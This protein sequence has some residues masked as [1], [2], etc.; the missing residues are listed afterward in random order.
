[1]SKADYYISSGG[2]A[3]VWPIPDFSAKRCLDIGIAAPLLVLTSPLLL[4]LGLMLAA[5]GGGVLFRQ[6][7]VGRG[8]RA[9]AMLKFRSMVPDA[10]ARLEQHLATHPA[11]AAEWARRQKLECDP[12]VTA[13]GRV[14]RRFS[15]DELPQLWNVLRGDMSFVG[16]RPPL[17]IYVARFPELYAEV[18]KS[19]PGITGLATLHFHAREERLLAPCR[20]AE[21]TDAVYMRRCVPRNARLDLIYQRNRTL[22]LDLVLLGQTLG[23][24]LFRPFRRQG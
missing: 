1:M 17:P 4:A 14:L 22:C 12:R 19:R 11:A 23:R 18:L 6:P 16:P 8:G 10:Q 15:L 21:E 7:R 3:P 24:V 9:F 20:T 2:F 5:G 13:L